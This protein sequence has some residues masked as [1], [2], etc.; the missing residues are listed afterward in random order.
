MPLLTNEEIEMRLDFFLVAKV[1]AVSFA[2]ET[3]VIDGCASL[4]EI[5]CIA[6]SPASQEGNR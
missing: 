5:S 1:N 3:R 2:S 4:A 6:A